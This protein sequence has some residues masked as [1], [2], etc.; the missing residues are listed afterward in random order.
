MPPMAFLS[1]P[2]SCAPKDW[3]TTTAKPL[4]RPTD[5]L[6]IRLYR[7]DVA[8]M[9]AIA[10]SPRQYPATIVSTME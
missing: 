6:M 8:P 4:F 10:R 2:S 7:A 5:M 3:V 9:A 1:F